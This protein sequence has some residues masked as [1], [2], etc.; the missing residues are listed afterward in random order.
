MRKNNGQGRCKKAVPS[1][2]RCAY[3]GLSEVRPFRGREASERRNI[4]LIG[5]VKRMLPEFFTKC[6]PSTYQKA[7]GAFYFYSPSFFKKVGEQILKAPRPFFKTRPSAL[8]H[9]L[10]LEREKHVLQVHA[11][12]EDYLLV[13]DEG[14][15]EGLLGL[16]T[17]AREGHLERAEV[18]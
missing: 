7:R 14:G 11:W 9:L 13:L 1:I 5:G 10:E 17:I 2:L 3:I 18:A 16:R 12:A 6:S 15:V 8:L 4:N